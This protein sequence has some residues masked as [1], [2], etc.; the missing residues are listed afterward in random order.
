MKAVLCAAGIDPSVYTAHS[1]RSAATSAA[2]AHGV[3]LQEILKTADWSNASTFAKF[4]NKPTEEV[5]FGKV[6]LSSSTCM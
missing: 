1:F 4:Y 2:F 5:S 3:K 6:V